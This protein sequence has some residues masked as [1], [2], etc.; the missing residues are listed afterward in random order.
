MSV[1]NS[2]PKLKRRR[3]PKLIVAALAIAGMATSISQTTV[4]PLQGALPTLLGARPEQSAWAVTSTLLVAAVCGPVSG[5]L[6]DMFGKR[7]VVVVVMALSVVGAFVCLLAN[8]ISTL[9]VGRAL[10]GPGI[11]VIPVGIAILRDEVPEA[12]LPSAIGLVTAT[13]ALG[14]A[15]GLPISAI[16]TAYFGWHAVFIVSAASLLI[17]TL[18]VSLAVPPSNLRQGGKFDLIGAL[19]LSAGMT[20]LLLALSLSPDAGW[21]S[22]IVLALA[23]G[24]LLVLV[25]WGFYEV[26]R[27][28]PLVDLRVSAR[29]PVLFT[30]LAALTM[31]IALFS[32]NVAYPQLLQAPT[33]TGGLG[34]PLIVA[35][36]VMMTS[37]VTMIAV[38]PFVGRFQRWLTPKGTILVGASLVAAGYCVCL[39]GGAHLWT[40]VAGY[41][42]QGMGAGLSFAAVP[43]IIMGAAPRSEAAAANGLNALM[44]S[45]GFTIA[46]AVVAALLAASSITYAGHPVPSSTGY[47]A[48]FL[49]GAAAGIVTAV[50]ISLVPRAR[51]LPESATS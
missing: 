5:R 20:S 50:L 42:L 16:T 21:T 34:Q 9:I 25:G 26:R 33:A 11:S 7:R 23:I 29:R 12:K 48:T 37:G 41:A 13:L 36:L 27:R 46:S 43:V 51:R 40:I 28:Q 47:H 19:G 49:F 39:I 22:P 8:D 1:A 10:Q 15:V 38:T 35:S 18:F 17:A 24:G 2:S 14:A 3:P 45:L 32:S 44:R 31:S 4:I 6:A 30:N